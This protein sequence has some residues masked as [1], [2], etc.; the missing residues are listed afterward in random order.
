MS[1]LQNFCS[2]TVPLRGRVLSVILLGLAALAVLL[3]VVSG[4]LL[5][6]E[7]EPELVLDESQEPPGH[8]QVGERVEDVL[9]RYTGCI[10]RV[11]EEGDR[12]L[13]RIHNLYCAYYV[14]VGPEIVEAV[15]MAPYETGPGKGLLVAD[16]QAGCQYTFKP[17]SDDQWIAPDAGVLMVARDDGVVLVAHEAGLRAL[18]TLLNNVR[19]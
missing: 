3:L 2:R 19:L 14:L 8:V 12:T 10:W 13:L 4:M 7:Q 15:L 18:E 9:Q 17:R 11:A 6:N 1:E 5:F 16:Y